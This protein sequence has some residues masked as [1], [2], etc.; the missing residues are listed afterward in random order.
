[1]LV[2]VV[3]RIKQVHLL[4]FSHKVEQVVEVMVQHKVCV[5]KA[6]KLI[7]AVELVVVVNLVLVETV[8]KE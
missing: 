4:E 6:V 7:K 5:E 8:V 3:G 2:V 1:M